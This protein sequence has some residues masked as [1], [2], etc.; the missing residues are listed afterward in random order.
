MKR[1]ARLFSIVAI[2]GMSACSGPLSPALTAEPDETAAAVPAAAAV[3]AV[4][5]G[6]A[7]QG[8]WLQLQL[9]TD[10]ADG[11]N[12]TQDIGMDQARKIYLVTANVVGDLPPILTLDASVYPARDF[13]ND[14][15]ALRQSL[16]V[17]IEYDD[18]REKVVKTIPLPSMV[19]A[20]QTPTFHITEKINLLEHLDGKPKTMLLIA[21]GEIVLHENGTD[22]DAIDP[23]TAT[24]PPERTGSLQ[25]NPLRINFE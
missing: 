8:I 18:G 17:E 20:K 13:P 2:F 14:P 9:S 16:K 19:V 7:D 11:Q 15:V 1:L 24:G 25:S 12:V 5:I 23:D 3:Q 21:K 4:D 10:T 22:P 6:D